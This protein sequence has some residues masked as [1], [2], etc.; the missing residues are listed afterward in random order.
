MSKLTFPDVIQSSLE[1]VHPEW[2][3]TLARGLS[4]IESASPGYLQEL[5]SA[6][7]F[8]TDN[9]IFA[10]F[11]LPPSSVKYVL[12]GEGPYPRAES[13]TGFAFMDGAV[14]P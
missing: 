7:F 1:Q 3:S 2:Q 8:P 5:T 4:A 9:R 11:S 14:I 12:I 10:A 13:A 6:D